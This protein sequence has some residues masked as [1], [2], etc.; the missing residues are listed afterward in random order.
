MIVIKLKF[1]KEE[2]LALKEIEI[3]IKDDYSEDDLL[4][5]EDSVANELMNH[6]DKDDNPLP[7]ALIY[8]AILDKI[9]EVN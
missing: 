8:E 4:E 2:I 5:L 3:S 7:K 6:F 1:N 9:S